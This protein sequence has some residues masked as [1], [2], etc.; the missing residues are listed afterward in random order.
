MVDVQIMELKIRYTSP[1]FQELM[2]KVYDDSKAKRE[3]GYKEVY[4]SYHVDESSL[5]NICDVT[6]VKEK[7]GI[8]NE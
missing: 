4:N 3:E 2:K 7:G 5:A 1:N 6:F 8:K